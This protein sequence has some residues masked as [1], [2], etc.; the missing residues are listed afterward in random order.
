MSSSWK[1]KLHNVDGKNDG[2]SLL[3][4]VNYCYADLTKRRHAFCFHTDCVFQSL[5]LSYCSILTNIMSSPLMQTEGKIQIL[6]AA[7]RQ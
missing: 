7:Q 4:Y 2:I 5:E 1:R 6:R 3:S